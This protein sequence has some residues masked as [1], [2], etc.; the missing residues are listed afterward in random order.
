[1]VARHRPFLRP[2][3]LTHLDDLLALDATV[4]ESLSALRR[5]G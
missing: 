3:Q 5:S 2:I 4:D 1:V